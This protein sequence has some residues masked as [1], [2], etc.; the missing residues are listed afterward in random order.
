MLGTCVSNV[1]FAWLVKPSAICQDYKSY[2]LFLSSTDSRQL[3]WLDTTWDRH[4]SPAFRLQRCRW[5]RYLLKVPS[6]TYNFHLFYGHLKVTADFSF[7]FRLAPD[8][9]AH[10][11]RGMNYRYNAAVSHMIWLRLSSSSTSYLSHCSFS[12]LFGFIAPAPSLLLSNNFFLWF[13]T[14]GSWKFN[15]F[16]VTSHLLPPGGWIRAQTISFWNGHKISRVFL[17]R[18]GGAERSKLS[19][20]LSSNFFQIPIHLVSGPE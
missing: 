16:F 18:G 14:L 15:F 8:I 7:L 9:S 3:N 1:L 12:L 17:S 10:R 6:A 4:Q 5:K 11:F 13:F 2:S 20:C 19:R